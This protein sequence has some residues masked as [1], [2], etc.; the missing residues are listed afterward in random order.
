MPA[1]NR[2]RGEDE[3]VIAQRDVIGD[4][5]SRTGEFGDVL[6]SGNGQATHDVSDGEDDRVEE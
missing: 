6:A 2:K 5:E 4:E 3:G 1:T